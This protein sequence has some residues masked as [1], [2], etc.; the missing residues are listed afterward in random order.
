[1]TVPEWCAKE[2]RGAA[3]R[4]VRL[5]RVAPATAYALAKGR[6]TRNYD[7]AVRVSQATRGA[8]GEPLVTVAEVW[9]SSVTS[10]VA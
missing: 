3:L 9:D 6:K 7:V 5:A 4:L 1:M 10:T 8:D 2:G